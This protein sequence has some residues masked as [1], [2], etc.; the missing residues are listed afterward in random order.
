MVNSRIWKF[1][2]AL[3]FVV[4]LTLA[5]QGSAAYLIKLKNG[6]EFITARYWQE[7]KQV[8]FDTYG[9]VFGVEKDLIIKIS[10]SDR[11]LPREPT[12]PFSS[13]EKRE[14]AVES[15]PATKLEAGEKD[16]AAKREKPTDT[17]SKPG[18]QKDEIILKEFG[19]LQ[20]RF[21]QLN[22]LPVNDVYALSSDIDSFRR[23]LQV[24]DLA[25]AHKDEIN[26]AGTLLRAIEGYLKA[27]GR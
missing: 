8:M 18:E 9:G 6:A 16:S 14:P 2:A 22:D 10:A 11:A 20:Q 17:V 15:A 26:A 3:A 13:S 7:G 12:S 24:S 4:N 23:K 19:L 21:S 25:E 5:S 1:A 27:S